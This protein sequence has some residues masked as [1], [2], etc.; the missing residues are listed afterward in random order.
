LEVFEIY[1]VSVIVYG[2]DDVPAFYC[3]GAGIALDA[4][5]AAQIARADAASAAG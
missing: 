1:I 3:R 5:V 4:R 2:C